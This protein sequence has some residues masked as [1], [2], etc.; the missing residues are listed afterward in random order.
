MAKPYKIAY[1]HEE[2]AAINKELTAVM[3]RMGTDKT[4]RI[5]VEHKIV[6]HG[7]QWEFYVVPKK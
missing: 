7:Q 1:S 6:K 3:K 4:H 5:H 2:K